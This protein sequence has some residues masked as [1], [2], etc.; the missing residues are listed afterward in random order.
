MLAPSEQR[1]TQTL[2]ISSG[3]A[4]RPSGTLPSCSASASSRLM[5]FA[6]AFW[7]ASPPG[8]IHS[9]L[10]TGPGATALTSTFCAAHRSAHARDSDSCAAFVTA[11]ATLVSD[12]RLPAELATLT[13]LPHPRSAIR[14]A[15]ARMSRMLAMTCSSH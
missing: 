2:A 10:A 4:K 6:L 5:P 13:I 9:S 14:G 11:Y 1:N 3:V 12:G 7:S 15:A 8:A